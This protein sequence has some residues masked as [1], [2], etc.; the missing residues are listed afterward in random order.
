M[1]LSSWLNRLSSRRQVRRPVLVAEIFEPR[2]L[3]DATLPSLI[4]QTSEVE[5]TSEEIVTFGAPE[6]GEDPNVIFYSLGGALPQAPISQFGSREEFGDYLLNRALARYEG[7]F[8]Q[9]EWWSR[10]P[11]YFRSGEFLARAD[12]LATP[13]HSETNVQVNGVDE[14]DVIENDGQNLFVLN[15]NDLVI[16]QAYPAGEMRELSR[17]H[18][19]GYAIAEYLDGNR[20]TVISQEYSYG[21]G[22]DVRGIGIMASRFAALP[23]S[24]TTV[25]STFDVTDRSRP[26]LEKQ[27]RLDG[28]YVDSRAFNGQVHLITSHDLSLPA[29][30]TDGTTTIDVRGYGDFAPWIVD[31]IPSESVSIQ[32]SDDMPVVDPSDRSAAKTQQIEVP[33]YESRESYIARVREQLD[34]LID[35][36]LPHYQSLTS[37][38]FATSGLISEMSAIARVTDSDSDSLLSV[39][40]IDTRGGQPGLIS[41]SSV[42]TDWTNGIHANRDHLYVFSPIYNDGGTQ[43]RVV[44]F[45]WGNGE[46]EIQLLASGVV[47]GTLLNQFS[48]DEHDGRLR[49]ATTTSHYDVETGVFTQANNLTILE[50]INGTL[51]EVGAVNGFASGERIYSVRYDGDR[52]FVVTFRQVDPLFVFDLSDPTAPVIRGE[53]K[54]PGTSS[55]LQLIDENHLLAVGRSFETQST[56]VS[57]YDIS[58]PTNPFE[59]DEDILPRW[60]WSQAE[61]DAKAI[62]WFG[63]SNTL[64]IPTSGYDESF[65]YRNE[66]VVFH[67]DVTQSGESAIQETGTVEDDGYIVRS[68]FIGEVLYAI[69]SNSVIATDINSPDDILGQVDFGANSLIA[70]LTL[71][72][73]FSETDD[74]AS[75]WQ[76]LDLPDSLDEAE[77]MLALAAVNVLDG[78]V[79]V[80]LLDA[81]ATVN[82]TLRNNTLTLKE[83]GH[84]TETVS[85]STASSLVIE[86]TDLGDRLN[87]TIG[88]SK[89]SPLNT[90]VINA[91]AG[92]DRVQL[93][94]VDQSS[95]ATITIN[96]ENGNDRVVAASG[97]RVGLQLNGGE[98]SD[99]LTGGRGNDTIDGGAGDDSMIGG[100]GNDVLIGRDG[101]DA[102]FGQDGNDSLSGGAGH[103]LLNGGND[104]DILLGGDGN[105]KLYG[106]AGN[107]I[108]LGEE[109][110]D[111]V[112]GGAGSRDTLVGGSGHNRV[113]G[114]RQ[115][116]VTTFIYTA[117]WLNLI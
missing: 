81:E 72:P 52:A 87:L 36:A 67:I 6:N 111:T 9:P 30:Q 82:A 39:V 45:A 83:R 31:V 79:R 73:V 89:N 80:S 69:S 3:M 32:P 64:A 35:E 86:G 29:P 78:T 23:S 76:Y 61:W 34:S 63:S 43:T 66:L 17:V 113:V 71:D 65:G 37:S 48:A 50:N 88:K 49:I 97:I 100:R 47:E 74:G 91:G 117:D 51:T 44:Q 90:I 4:E 22:D 103:D 115:E 85:L 21:G 77:G 54:V 18:F 75:D 40:S 84:Q 116:V 53:L 20:L 62:G 28:S 5:A 56:K 112:D 15:G 10:G 107:D 94:A 46:R 7:L 25:V 24:T 19:E 11:V 26:T 13:E 98:G 33:V 38:G 8:G 109:G 60:T 110:D 16:L 57:L 114:R 95:S 70:T 14:G 68:A 42:V 104:N 96:G 108:I 12:A 92:D 1:K 105:D 2:A 106:G 41:S 27:T 59:I 55:Y 93:L 99:S 58:D 102:I 101:A